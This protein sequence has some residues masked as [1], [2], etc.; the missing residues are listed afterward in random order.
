MFEPPI[1]FERVEAPYHLGNQSDFV[2]DAVVIGSGAGGAAVATQ[3]AE[4]WDAHT[5]A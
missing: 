4:E 5:H 1:I 3:L 2:A